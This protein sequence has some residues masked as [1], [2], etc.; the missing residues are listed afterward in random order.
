MKIQSYIGKWLRFANEALFE[1]LKVYW[2]FVRS[3]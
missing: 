1:E 3:V 2:D